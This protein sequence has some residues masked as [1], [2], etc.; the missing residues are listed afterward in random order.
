[1]IRRT[2]PC[3]AGLACLIACGTS[4]YDETRIRTRPPVPK[5]VQVVTAAP[6]LYDAAGN[7]L[8][9]EG[10]VA[11]LELPRGLNEIP[12]LPK[13]IRSYWAEDVPVDRIQAFFGAR[14][15][16]DSVTNESGGTHFERGRPETGVTPE[17]VRI[18]VSV[19]RTGQNSVRVDI[20]EHIP[21]PLTRMITDAEARR[22][23]KEEFRRAE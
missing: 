1:M 23:A 4:T 12:N 19:L 21:L 18:D 11:W 2:F 22:L 6:V 17:T 13:G 5:A 20:E 15:I 14:M 10:R 7:L 8:P 9:G 3:L 16:A